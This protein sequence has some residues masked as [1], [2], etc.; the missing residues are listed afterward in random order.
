MRETVRVYVWPGALTVGAGVMGWLQEVPLFYWTV[1]VIL[2]F[3]GA[4]TGLLRFDEWRYRNSALHKLV[5]RDIRVTRIVGDDK[6]LVAVRLG[7]GLESAAIFPI[8]FKGRF[9]DSVYG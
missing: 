4:T 6:R 2:A 3:A 9:K 8:Q 1:G 5:F 7:F